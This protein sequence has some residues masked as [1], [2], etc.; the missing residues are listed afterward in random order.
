MYRLY[1]TVFGSL[2]GLTLWFCTVPM[3]LSTLCMAPWALVQSGSHPLGGEV[4]NSRPRGLGPIFGHPGFGRMA[5]P[6]VRPVRART[7]GVAW[8]RKEKSVWGCVK[9]V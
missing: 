7:D 4:A 2:V 8:A 5:L 6:R 1:G 3:F 9:C